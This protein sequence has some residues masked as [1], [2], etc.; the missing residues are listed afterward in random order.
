MTFSIRPIEPANL[1]AWID[2]ANQ[3][4]YW[5][6]DRESPLFEDGLRPSGE[7]FLRLGAYTAHGE[8]V[9]TAEAYLG[10]YGERW[11]DRAGGFVSVSARYRRQGLGTRLLEE[12][13]GFAGRAG[14]TWLEGE[15]RQRDL[16]VVSRVLAPR[17]YRELER[18]QASRQEPARVETSE[19]DRLRDELSRHGIQLTGFNEIDSPGARESLYRCAMAIHRDMPHEAHVDWDDPPKATYF[20]L[21][22]ANP[23]SLR[24]AIFVARDGEEIVG[25][26]YLARRPGGD[27][28]VGDTGVLGSHRR[29]GIG[30]ALKLMAT[31]YAAERGF[32]YAYTDNRSDN[33]GMLAINR[34]LGFIPHEVLVV[35]EKTIAK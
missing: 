4:R 9:G 7:P 10:E 24:D 20:R 21:M 8:I 28:E 16:D 33:Q 27:A 32:R 26:T 1:Q 23:L 25:L 17:Q 35:F 19:L 30:R 15:A 11:K 18:Y 14:V 22:F 5:Q 2:L 13:E 29:R 31:R 34:Q 3:C 6:V 12:V